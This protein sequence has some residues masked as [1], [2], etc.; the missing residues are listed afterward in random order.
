MNRTTRTALERSIKKWERIILGRDV[1][2]G[3]E[4]CALCKKFADKEDYLTECEG[5]PVYEK[6]GQTHCRNTPYENFTE[7]FNDETLLLA[8]CRD[9]D[10]LPCVIGP[11]TMRAA[12]REY[13][14]LCSL[15]EKE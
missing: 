5:C 10:Q 7:T 9:Y 15:R 12:I 3:M 2:K 4:N 11:K 8:D 14:F 1:D 6:T 13:E